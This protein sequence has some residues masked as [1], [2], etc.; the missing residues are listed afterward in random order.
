MIS[1]F[2][3]GQI[4]NY[5]ELQATRESCS[6]APIYIECEKFVTWGLFRLPVWNSS[7]LW[8]SNSEQ[9]GYVNYEN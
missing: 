9:S 2:I 3:S 1:E 8:H 4:Y 5:D 6:N 7:V